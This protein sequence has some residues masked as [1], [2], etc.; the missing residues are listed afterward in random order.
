MNIT[1]PSIARSF[2]LTIGLLLSFSFFYGNISAQTYFVLTEIEVIPINPDDQTPVS[3][4]ISG[5]RTNPCSFLNTSS[6]NINASFT[7]LNMDWDNQADTDATANCP[8][9]SV[10]WDTT[11]QLGILNGGTN[12]LYFAGNNYGLSGVNNPTVIQVAASACDNGNTEISVTNTNDEGPGS[13]RQAIVCAN[14]QPGFNRIVFNLISEGPDTIRV[15]ETSGFELPSIFDDSTFIDATTHPAF[16]NNGDFSPK[17][18]LDGQYH[19]WDAAINALFVRADHCLIYGLEIINFPDDA[20]DVLAG[21]DVIIGGINR[22]NV[23]HSNGLDQDFFASNPGQ[24][25]WE[26]CGIVIR[27]GAD[28]AIIR[29]NYIGTNFTETTPNGNE[30]C[31]ILIR[32]SGDL[33]QIGGTTP[34]M[35]NV[36]VNNAIGLIIGGGTNGTSILQNR[37]YCND[38]LALRISNT[39]NNNIVPP[40]IALAEYG[41]ISGTAL[42]NQSVALYRNDNNGCTAA[43]CQG[44][45]YLGTA[46][47]INGSWSL[48]EPFMDGITLNT[49]DRVTAI[50]TDL[51]G[52]SSEFAD[53]AVF[54]ACALALTVDSV[55]PTSC[56]AENG[57]AN[58][59]VSGGT[60]PYVFSYNGETS[61]NSNLINLGA[62]NYSVIVTDGNNCTA[63]NNFT[64]LENEPP[65][66]SVDLQNN[67]TCN[68]ANGSFTLSVNEGAAPFIYT[69]NG[70]T[71]GSP[72]FNN[73][74]SGTYSVTVTD[75]DGCTDSITVTLADSNPPII[76]ISQLN[77]ATCG[78]SNGSLVVVAG[79]GTAP[80]VYSIDGVEQNN[81]NFNNLAEGIYSIGIRDGNACT[82]QLNAVI[83]DTPPVA[84]VAADIINPVCGNEN[85]QF[86]VNVT[87]GSTP[88]S[89]T[90]NGSPTNQIS[91]TNLGVGTYTVVATDAVGCT[92]VV[93]VTLVDS[94]L[95]E[96]MITQQTDDT[97]NDGTG[98]F[99]LDVAGGQAPFEFDLGTGR[100]N[101]GDFTDLS[102]GNYS[103]TVTDVNSC[104]A[105]V[106]VVLENN[107]TEPLSTFT[108][109]L[110]DGQVMAQ[111][112]AVGVTSLEWDFGDG[113]SSTAANIVHDYPGAGVYSLCLTVMN[114]CGSVTTCEDL[115]IVLPLSDHNIEGNIN[116][117]DG[118]GIGQ[119][120][121]A[122]TDQSVLT[123]GAAGTYLFENLPQEGNYEI[124]PTKDINHRNGVTVLDIIKIRAH[125]LFIDTLETPYEYIAADVNRSGGVTV[126]DL[127][128]LQQMVLESVDRFPQSS[129]DFLPADYTF[130]YGSQALKYTYP[131]SI[132]V[133]DLNTDVENIDFIGVKIGDLNESNNPSLLS[134]GY[135]SWQIADRSV[136]AGEIIEIPVRML[137]GQEL[138]GYEAAL[139]FDPTNLSLQAV[140][141]VTDYQVKDGQLKMLWYTE[142]AQNQAVSVTSATDLVTLRFLAH[143]DLEKISDAINF[144]TADARQLTYDAQQT[145]RSI[146]WSFSDA[147]VTNVR[148]LNQTAPKL[149][150]NPF[151]QQTFL[152]FEL[153]QGASVSLEVYDLTGKAILKEEKM[154]MEGNHKIAISGS[155]FSAAGTY[156]YRL[157]I[158]GQIYRGRIIKQ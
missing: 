106:E 79:G 84:I 19:I 69:F 120:E 107:G 83:G 114:D 128:L 135:T 3:I 155:R 143:T 67:A 77:R 156:F 5:L 17:V 10:P 97:C 59:S 91:F 94:G 52:N 157:K 145:E 150:P 133:N 132:M 22:G 130:D 70:A 2:L 108:F 44:G 27:G 139:N 32:D 104:S 55:E 41:N 8:N 11:F 13:L 12:A 71:S 15:G 62:G 81:G 75:A 122:C 146:E 109:E 53:C 125:L 158:G 9:F 48:S 26:G 76:A 142:A 119:V 110:L 86:S 42:P 101:T 63:I 136:T 99:S 100:I 90:L 21:D 60:P 34:G 51:T 105:V 85:G 102:E 35:G 68:S 25:P 137:L 121:V 127:V 82:A 89:Y 20:I 144:A 113:G 138:L 56:S 16:G 46:N 116:R 66:L 141:G 131:Q 149:Y 93:T 148:N 72:V 7:V 103:V 61:N 40:V 31:G 123:T 4:R 50:A 57:V 6:L 29:G 152:T 39:A 37:F 49:G 92:E 74:F 98:G 54:L 65:V 73:L 117:M 151:Q 118:S 23:I 115:E 126:F 153:S 96:I 88:F 129:W 1:L 33:H 30:F 43:P 112:T 140:T 64:I 78:D 80:F 95:L 24:G 47:V 154:R 134:N 28:R 18:V 36:V 124:T 87:G 58:L 147:V 111:S 38:S 45:T 14:A